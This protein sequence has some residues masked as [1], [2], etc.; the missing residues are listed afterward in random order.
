MRG[1]KP[2]AQKIKKVEGNPGH[3]KVIEF[4]EAKARLNAAP[5]TNRKAP[6]KE[7]PTAPPMPDHLSKEERKEWAY[8]TGELKKLGA[9]ASCDLAA[10]TAYCHFSALYARIMSTFND[11]DEGVVLTNP[12]GRVI[13]NPALEMASEALRHLLRVCAELGLT[14]VARTRLPIQKE[15]PVDA[16][17][18]RLKG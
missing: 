8:V 10:I 11:S 14:P 7:D 1:R 2:K 12:S 3:K 6:P 16:L 4:P 5:K 9:L 17:E 18:E 15:N 13:P